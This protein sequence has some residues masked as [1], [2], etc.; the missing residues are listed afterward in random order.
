MPD[1][2]TV[3]VMGV[4]AVV[5]GAEPDSRGA[6][7]SVETLGDE[8]EG[9]IVTVPLGPPAEVGTAESA[10]LVPLVFPGGTVVTVRGGLG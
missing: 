10:S 6:W 2:S 4:R 9:V 5:S 7:E 8:P 3:T 1:G